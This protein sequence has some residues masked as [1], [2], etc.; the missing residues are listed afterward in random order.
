MHAGQPGRHEARRSCLARGIR[1]RRASRATPRATPRRRSRA[2]RAAARASILLSCH[3]EQW[4]PPRACNQRPALAPA[5][6][7][8]RA[9]RRA[10]H[11]YRTICP[12]GG[13][14]WG[15]AGARKRG[16]DLLA[17]VCRP[18][19]CQLQAAPAQAPDT[20]CTAAPA[21]LD[22]GNSTQAVAQQ[23]PEV[24]LGV[25]KP[26]TL[27]SKSGGKSAQL[28]ASCHH[29]PA[30]ASWSHGTFLLRQMSANRTAARVA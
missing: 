24:V 30:T 18:R 26:D 5:A 6:G 27:A 20:I 1:T 8:P 29:L 25:L 9:P 10:P 28:G 3:A 16:R 7:L 2:R 11:P 14:A 21:A 23:T 22:G 13:G 4:G 12:V 19:H 17:R 15:P